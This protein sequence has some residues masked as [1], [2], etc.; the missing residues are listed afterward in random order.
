MFWFTVY[1]VSLVCSPLEALTGSKNPKRLP[2]DIQHWGASWGPDKSLSRRFLKQDVAGPLHHGASGFQESKWMLPG[3]NFKV[4]A[5]IWEFHF[6]P[7]LLVSSRIFPDTRV[8]NRFKIYGNNLTFIFYKL[9]G[10][11]LNMWFSKFHLKT[12]PYLKDNHNTNVITS[13]N[14]SG[15]MDN[16]QNHL[17]ELN[18]IVYFHQRYD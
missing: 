14:F 10:T 1:G 6:C 8:G 3:I 7:I 4:V 5:H 17:L 11:P 9:C 12:L 2:S 15:K 16:C 13:F 18:K